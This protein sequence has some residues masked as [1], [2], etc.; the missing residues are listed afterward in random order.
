MI[1]LRIIALIVPSHL[2]VLILV[3]MSKEK[4]L[5]MGDKIVYENVNQAKKKAETAYS[6]F[7]KC[8]EDNGLPKSKE[9]PRWHRLIELSDRANELMDDYDYAKMIE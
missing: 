8:L 3:E 1:L 9:D 6:E 7:R 5:N 4:E 2:N